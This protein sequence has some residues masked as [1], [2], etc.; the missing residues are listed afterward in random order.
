MIVKAAGCI[1][2]G[3][4]KLTSGSEGLSLLSNQTQA[5]GTLTSTKVRKRKFGISE[6]QGGRNVTKISR[7]K[8]GTDDGAKSATESTRTLYDRMG[9]EKGE[10][11]M[12]KENPRKVSP[13]KEDFRFGIWHVRRCKAR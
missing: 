11:K 1:E 3:V 5:R 7:S 10:T 2:L 13:K 8:I 12:H 6:H 4:D 9:T